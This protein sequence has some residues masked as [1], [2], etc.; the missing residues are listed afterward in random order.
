M[1]IN[2]SYLKMMTEPDAAD[3]INNDFKELGAAVKKL[4]SHVVP[5]GSLGYGTSFLKWV[6][7]FAAM[8]RSRKWIAFVGVVLRL[9]FPKRF[10]E[11]LELPAALILLIVVAPS[12]FA[13]TLRGDWIEHIRAAGGFRDAFT[14]PGGISNTVGIIILFVYP[15]WAIVLYILQTFTT[16]LTIMIHVEWF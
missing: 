8:G 9:F 10:P 4:A 14:K 12:L 11:W 16:M 13:D 5:L 3:L 6:A 15:V 1:A 2:K 7:S